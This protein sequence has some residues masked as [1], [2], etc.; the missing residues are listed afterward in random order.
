MLSLVKTSRREA[1][2]RGPK[3]T[4]DVRKPDEGIVKALRLRSDEKVIHLKRIRD[5]T[6]CPWDHVVLCPCA[7]VPSAGDI[8]SSQ[9][10]V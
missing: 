6:S 5:P 8:R 4:F 7:S 10:A 9:F 3:S 2:R 1:P